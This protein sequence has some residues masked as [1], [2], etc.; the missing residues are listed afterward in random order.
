MDI[1]LNGSH[2]DDDGRLRKIYNLLN[3]GAF[4]KLMNYIFK[5]EHVVQYCGSTIPSNTP[6]QLIHLYIYSILF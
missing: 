4:I 3:M 5:K 2:I 1:E 6:F